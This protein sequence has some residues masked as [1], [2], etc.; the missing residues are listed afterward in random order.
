M[1]IRAL[2]GLAAAA[3][4]AG[5]STMAVDSTYIGTLTTDD[6]KITATAYETL[7]GGMICCGF[8][9][10][11]YNAHPVDMCVHAYGGGGGRATALVPAGETRNV[12]W[13][14]STGWVEGTYGITTWDPRVAPCVG[15]GPA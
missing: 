12:L 15:M 6:G 2:S 7:A 9:I 11:A 14:D 10:Q 4:L 5:C 3:L 13:V 8:R 1:K